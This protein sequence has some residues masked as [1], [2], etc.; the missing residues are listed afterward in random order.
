MGAQRNALMGARRL[1]ALRPQTLMGAVPGAR[2][3]AQQ[4]AL[5]SQVGSPSPDDAKFPLVA[6]PFPND[7]EHLLA[8]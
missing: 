5:F 3:V 4:G 2:P 8:A 6:G 1:V 7:A